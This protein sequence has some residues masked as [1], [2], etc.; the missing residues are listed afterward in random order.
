MCL[1]LVPVFFCG[2]YGDSTTCTDVCKDSCNAVA[3]LIPGYEW[4]PCTEKE[5]KNVYKNLDNMCERCIDRVIADFFKGPL[6]DEVL[7]FINSD[8]KPE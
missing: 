8:W 3:H 5:V 2:H 6:P 4:T 7:A 1:H